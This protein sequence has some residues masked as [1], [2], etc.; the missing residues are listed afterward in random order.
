MF[1]CV[2]NFKLTWKLEK[3]K[4]RK[5]IF[6][7]IWLNFQFDEF[8]LKFDIHYSSRQLELSRLCNNCL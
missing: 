7:K 8:S 5:N 1:S 2:Q 6:N 4:N 3:K